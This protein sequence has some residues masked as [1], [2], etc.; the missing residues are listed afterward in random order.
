M[1][2]AAIETSVPGD[3]RRHPKRKHTELFIDVQEF[4]DAVS[5]LILELRLARGKKMRA[6]SVSNGLFADQVHRILTTDV[7]VPVRPRTEN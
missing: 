1:L 7:I 6:L 5:V 2:L 3:D 4:H